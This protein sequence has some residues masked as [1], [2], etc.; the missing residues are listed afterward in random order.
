MIHIRL[1]LRLILMDFL[2]LLEDLVDKVTIFLEK[3]EESRAEV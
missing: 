2:K 3:I 1:Q